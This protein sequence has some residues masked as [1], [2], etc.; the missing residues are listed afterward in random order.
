[1]R[2]AIFDLDGTLLDSMDYWASVAEEFFE[3]NGI[4]PPADTGRCFLE[5][6]MGWCHELWRSMGL[7]LSFEET[8]DQIYALMDK[9]YQTVI[10]VKDGAIDMLKR[11]KE[12]GVKMCLATATD[13]ATVEMALARL[14]IDKYFSRIFTCTEVGKGKK[15][16]LIYELA[17][18]HLGTPKD[19]TY[20]FEDAYYAIV[21][22]HD[23]GFNIVGVYDKNVY[24]PVEQIRPLCKFF[25]EKDSHYALPSELL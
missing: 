21:T 24:V 15:Y 9:K 10:S 23:A 19:E 13:R 8:R 16:P 2:G 18:E 3:I 7:S 5:N 20:I 11:L 17:L 4:L 1:M 6:G 12:S 14:G 22:A 25:L